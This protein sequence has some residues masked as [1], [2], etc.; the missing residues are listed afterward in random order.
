M[1]VVNYLCN[2]FGAEL[3][4]LLKKSYLESNDIQTATLKLIHHLFG[5]FG[6]IVL[7][8]DNPAFKKEMLPV[9]EDEL[10][11]QVATKLVQKNK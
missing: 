5:E 11:N 8:P 3:V 4:E 6:L 9:F 2:L 7:I 1:S 10:F